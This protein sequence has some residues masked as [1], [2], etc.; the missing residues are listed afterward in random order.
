MCQR[1]FLLRSSYEVFFRQQ[2]D[3]NADTFFID[4]DSNN[5]RAKHV[6]TKAGFKF[7]GEFTSDNKYWEFEGEKT[8]LMVMRK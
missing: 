7:V 1:L 4:P 5:P 8:L 2:V 6:Y 3:H